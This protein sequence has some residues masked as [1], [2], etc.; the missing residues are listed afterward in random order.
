MAGWEGAGQEERQ[1]WIQDVMPFGMLFGEGW[2]G[3]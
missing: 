3:W 2:G 1:R